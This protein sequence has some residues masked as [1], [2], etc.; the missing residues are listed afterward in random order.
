MTSSLESVEKMYILKE[1]AADYN[2]ELTD[3]DEAAI[4]DAASQE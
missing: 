2:I 4:A 1:K 3:D